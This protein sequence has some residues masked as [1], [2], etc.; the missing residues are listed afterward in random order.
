MRSK[1]LYWAPRILAILFIAFLSIFA[2]DVFSK[3]YSSLELLVALFIHLIPSFVL[4]AILLIAWKWE[5]AGGIIFIILALGFTVF[6]NTY[7]QGLLVFL[8]ISGPPFLIGALFWISSLEAESKAVRKIK[9]IK[10]KK[11]GKAKKKK[12]RK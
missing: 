3:G 2:L 6:F 4:L 1:Y 10:T 7:Q 5:K 8:A 11:A 12:R 9:S